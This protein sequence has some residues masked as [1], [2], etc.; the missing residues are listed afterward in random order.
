ML[1]HRFVI[2]QSKIEGLDEMLPSD[3]DE[4]EMEANKIHRKQKLGEEAEN[5]DEEEKGKFFKPHQRNLLSKEDMLKLRKREEF[6]GEGYGLFKKGTY[7][8]IEVEVD[9]DIAS[10]LDAEKVIAL[11]AVE[12][13]EEAFGY[14]RVKIK[15]HRWYPHVL[16]NKDPLIF[17][18][19]WRRFQSIPVL[20]TEDQNERI[21]MLK[22]TPKFG[23]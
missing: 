8:R 23:F 14:M 11:C 21:R 10:M 20:T 12:K 6:I 16:K 9:K 17:S 2:G 4:E 3:S 22:Y 18:I 19:G 1:K 5:S 7:V 13:R 15:K